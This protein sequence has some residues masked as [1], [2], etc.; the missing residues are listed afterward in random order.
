M[1]GRSTQASRPKR[2]AA[3]AD[4]DAVFAFLADRQTMTFSAGDPDRHAH[5][6]G[7]P[8]Q[9][10]V[11]KIAGRRFPFLDLDPQQATTACEAEIAGQLMRRT[12]IAVPSRTGWP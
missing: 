10:D 7:V 12:S 11:Y 1:V 9:L 2:R 5:G 3:G 4:Q 8:R 6:R